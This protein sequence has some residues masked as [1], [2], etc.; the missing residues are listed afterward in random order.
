MGRLGEKVSED[1]GLNVQ[2]QKPIL[3]SFQSTAFFSKNS[4]CSQRGVNKMR[5][6][7]GSF[8]VK[9]QQNS[10]NNEFCTY[11]NSVEL[12]DFLRKPVIKKDHFVFSMSDKIDTPDS[13]YWFIKIEQ[14]YIE[15]SCG[16]SITRM[17]CLLLRP[18]IAVLCIRPIL[19]R[20]IIV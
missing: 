3:Q 15:I 6:T 16:S 7:A 9:S 8:R 4:A 18:Q 13:I 12:M 17:D 20:G 19:G 1:C 2:G 5:M 11:S 14:N 10:L